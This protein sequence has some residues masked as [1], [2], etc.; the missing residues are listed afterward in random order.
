MSY[1]SILVHVDHS[2]HAAERLRI[3]TDLAV[4]HDAYLIGAAMSG[5]SRYLYLDTMADP[6]GQM[7]AAQL[8]LMRTKSAQAM[9]QF[10]AI[11]QR[12]G[13][14]RF[15]NRMVDDDPEGGLALQA[16]YCDLVV[17]S[18]PD[19]HEAGFGLTGDLPEY[20]V[21]N[22]ARPVLIVPYAGSFTTVGQ[23]ALVAWDGSIEATRA[24]TSAL[25]LLRRAKSVTV[26]VF[27]ALRNVGTHGAEPGA[28]LALYLARHGIAVT[29]L[30]EETRVDIGNAV[31]SLASDRGADL[32]VMGGYGHTR[33]R[34]MLLGG[35]TL[36]V[37]KSM[38]L[39][40]LMAH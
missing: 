29:V 2:R 3:A 7:L 38:T 17:V 30:Q 31:L 18:Q 33:F 5:I 25:P 1:Q 36:T 8:D 34:E 4:V 22:C 37:L 26:V 9:A 11:G 23:T 10:E 6:G 15:E 40:V 21:L 27:N 39:P 32:L 16:R 24:V 35:I 12:V 13:P 28:D 14:G 20:V 19:P